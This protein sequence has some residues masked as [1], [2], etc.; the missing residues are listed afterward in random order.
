MGCDDF[1]PQ[2]RL[3]DKNDTDTMDD[4]NGLKRPARLGFC[5][6]QIELV[7][8][9]LRKSL[10]IDRSDRLSVLKTS[11][12]SKKSN[13]RPRLA[14]ESPCTDGARFQDRTIRYF[15]PRLHALGVWQLA[16]LNR[17]KQADLIT[18]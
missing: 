9:H 4:V 3:I 12:H 15:K 16:S 6:Y 1:N 13:D 7:K 8:H 5:E 14:I 17:W 10:V 18:R 11:H 2:R